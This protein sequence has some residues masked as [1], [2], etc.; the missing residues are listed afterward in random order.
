MH[1]F[2]AT[3]PLKANMNQKGFTLIEVIIAMVLVVVG[4]VLISQAFSI[5][6]RA[7]S[8]SDKSTIAKFLLEQKIAEVESLSVASLQSE[9]GDFGTDY[10]DYT[11][12]TE[13]TTTDLENLRQVVI[14]VQWKHDNTTRNIS[15]TK[16]L[17]DKGE[18]TT[19]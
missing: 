8:V 4:L 12:Q 19:S 9:S 18:T 2:I 15:I 17:A 7:V 14:T 16:Y 11:Y 10:P 13:V 3:R 6:L 1:E 5:G